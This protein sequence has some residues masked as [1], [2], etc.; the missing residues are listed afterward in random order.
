MFHLMIYYVTLWNKESFYGKES[1]VKR[2]KS[3]EKKYRKRCLINYNLVVKV[4]NKYVE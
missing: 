1:E 3:D 4:L 2:I